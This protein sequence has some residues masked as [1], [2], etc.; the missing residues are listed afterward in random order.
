MS[1]PPPYAPQRPQRFNPYNSGVSSR[2]GAP[3]APNRVD[4]RSILRTPSPTLSEYNVLH[5]VKE[6]RTWKQNIK[7]YAIIAVV[8]TFVILLSVFHEQIIE[9]LEPSSEWLREHK[10]GPLIP[11]AI[12]IVLSIPP[13]IGSEI[14]GMFIGV[15]WD[16]G[17]AF[18][19]ASGKGHLVLYSQTTNCPPSRCASRRNIELLAR[20]QSGALK[21]L[22]D[23]SSLFKYACTARGE[24]ME[25][26][27]H[28]YGLLAHVV[29]KG[30]F[31]IVLVIRYSAIP[32]HFATAVFSTVGVPFFIFLAAAVLS[33]PRHFL[34]VYIGWMLR[35]EN[36]GSEKKSSDIIEKVVL[37]LTI[38]VT[39]FALRWIKRKMKA[40][41]EEYIY[42]R[43]KGRQ[44]AKVGE[45]IRV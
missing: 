22:T 42:L 33:L 3:Y 35:P 13:L 39:I 21:S 7:R 15:T 38:L 19:I 30:G 11:I 27:D 9:A 26:K 31:L 16:L 28:S 1:Y 8:L 2:P 43:R 5:E 45:D 23:P 12:M 17:L 29:R 41:R 20:S 14:V 44:G 10:G 4:P 32:P 37:G 25:K 34:P 18:L 36:S 24:K 6:K 40:A